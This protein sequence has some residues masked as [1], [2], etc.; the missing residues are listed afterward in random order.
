MLNFKREKGRYNIEVRDEELK[1]E[2]HQFMVNS[3]S[4][5][6]V[7]VI[8]RELKEINPNASCE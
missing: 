2:F 8:C 4:S 3:I 5:F 1:E 7:E 6:D